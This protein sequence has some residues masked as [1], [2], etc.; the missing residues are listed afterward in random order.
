MQNK[1]NL[2]RKILMWKIGHKYKQTKTHQP[3]WRIIWK[4]RTRKGDG[5]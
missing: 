5:G 2:E 3:K 1:P 4:G